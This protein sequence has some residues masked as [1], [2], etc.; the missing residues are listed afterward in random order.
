MVQRSTV[1]LLF[2]EDGSW[3]LPNNEKKEGDSL[4]IGQLQMPGFPSS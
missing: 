1:V 2:L 3:P 4:E